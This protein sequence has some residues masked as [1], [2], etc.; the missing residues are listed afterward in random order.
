M[1]YNF[2]NLTTFEVVSGEHKRK[3]REIANIWYDQGHEVQYCITKNAL[4][5]EPNPP[6][7]KPY[8]KYMK[9]TEVQ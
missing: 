4:H 6:V 9:I 1:Y 8:K 3:A 5:E 2:Y 7:L